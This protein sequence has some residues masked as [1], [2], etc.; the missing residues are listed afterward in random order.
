MEEWD[1]KIW[2]VFDKFGIIMPFPAMHF[3]EVGARVSLKIATKGCIWGKKNWK[4]RF[5][6][7]F[8]EAKMV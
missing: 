8:S 1:Q 5:L 4:F 7:C 6:G 2:N 3:L